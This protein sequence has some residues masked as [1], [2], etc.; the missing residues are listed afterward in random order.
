MEVMKLV[1]ESQPLA[2]VL[3]SEKVVVAQENGVVS[4]VYL[5]SNKILSVE[6][7]AVAVQIEIHKNSMYVSTKP[8]AIEI[9]EENEESEEVYNNNV[10]ANRKTGSKLWKIDIL[11]EALVISKTFDKAGGFAI[12]NDK[13]YA[14]NIVSYGFYVL[15][16]GLDEIETV[17]VHI[18][19]STRRPWY[20]NITIIDDDLFLTQEEERIRWFKL[21]NK[22]EEKGIVEP[23][24][25]FIYETSFISINAAPKKMVKVGQYVLGILTSG[26]PYVIDFLA[27]K[28]VVVVDPKIIFTLNYKEQSVLNRVHAA[29]SQCVLAMDRYRII[30]ADAKLDT[31]LYGF[32]LDEIDE[33]LN[34]TRLTAFGNYVLC[35]AWTYGGKYPLIILDLSKSQEPVI[36]KIID[37]GV[38]SGTIKVGVDE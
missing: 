25:E 13:L 18:E 10:L 24:P 19:P 26:E 22:I 6:L 30:V 1:N 32:C 35:Y 27:G 15:S 16:L 17:A 12:N 21:G 33:T 14:C 28:P 5:N 7:N 9:T 29:T 20:S 38:P 3:D 31:V 2:E 23:E 36:T 4:A 34:L 8:F 11:E 37:C